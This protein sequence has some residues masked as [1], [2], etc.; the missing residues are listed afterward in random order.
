MKVTNREY[1]LLEF[2]YTGNLDPT[3][4]ILSFPSLTLKLNRIDPICQIEIIY[5]IKCNT[6]GGEFHFK[7]EVLVDVDFE[8]VNPDA[9]SLLYLT[10][11]A[12]GYCYKIMMSECTHIRKNTFPT[13][14]IIEDQE[15]LRILQSEID[16]LY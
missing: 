15:I 13:K 14:P 6:K 4:K 7:I 10:N 2:S 16:E 12:L 11:K 9:E 1:T 8:N 5:G 3:K